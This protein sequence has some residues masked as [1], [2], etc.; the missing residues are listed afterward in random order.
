MGY[1]DDPSRL[2]WPM[3]IQV[4]DRPRKIEF[5]EPIHFI[6]LIKYE[7]DPCY[8]LIISVF[9]VGGYVLYN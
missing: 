5:I 2:A 1:T 8:Y 7:L 4:S 9:K 3:I 6:A